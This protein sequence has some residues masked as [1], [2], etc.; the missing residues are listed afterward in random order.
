MKTMCPPGHHHNDFVV[1]HALGHIMYG[2][3]ISSILGNKFMSSVQLKMKR[4]YCEVSQH[5]KEPMQC[6]TGR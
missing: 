2:L 1:T 3:G 5:Q 4:T 6:H